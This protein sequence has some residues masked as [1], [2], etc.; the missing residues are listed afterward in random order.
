MGRSTSASAIGDTFSEAAPINLIVKGTEAIAPRTSSIRKG[1]V[2]RSQ[3]VHTHRQ[4]AILTP[5]RHDRIRIEHRLSSVWTRDII[6]YPGMQTGRGEYTIRTSAESLLR[7]FSIVRPSFMTRRN[8]NS[9]RTVAGKRIGPIPQDN[10]KFDEKGTSDLAV[11]VE[12]Q[13]STV[14][15]SMPPKRN[16]NSYPS[17]GGHGL[18]KGKKKYLRKKLSMSLFKAW[19]ADPTPPPP[20]PP[21]PQ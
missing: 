14:S 20:V 1:S 21:V 17:P 9:V 2:G 19:P 8:T 6:P 10:Q 12:G 7:K 13:I 16:R 15:G 4:M 11:G 5:K 3:T 18:S